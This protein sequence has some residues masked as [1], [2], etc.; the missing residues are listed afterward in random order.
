[1]PP[2]GNLIRFE[3]FKRYDI[4]PPRQAGDVVFVSWDTASKGGDL[5]NYSVATVWHGKTETK[6]LFLIDV[7]RA[8]L[9]FPAL[10][11]RV[12]SLHQ[13]WHAQWTVIEDKGS[14]TALIQDIRYD[15]TLKRNRI[16]IDEVN[17]EGDKVMRMATVSPMVEEGRV[18]LPMEAAWLDAFRAEVMAFPRGRHDDQVDSMSQALK[19]WQERTSGWYGVGYVSGGY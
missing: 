11:A 15:S 13:R 3:W 10:R 5:T 9:E 4:L 8:K 17:P 7:V 12:I 18:Y 16:G 2:E 6:E 1:V 19:W 14:G